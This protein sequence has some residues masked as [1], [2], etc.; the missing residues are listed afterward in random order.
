MLNPSEEPFDF[1]L[2]DSSALE[3]VRRRLRRV[4]QLARQN[5]YG[6][7]FGLQSR[8]TDG[9]IL[10]NLLGQFTRLVE[11]YLLDVEARLKLLQGRDV[12]LDGPV[13]ASCLGRFSILASSG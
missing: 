8:T 9:P 10:L 1:L 4:S 11:R 7:Y 3:N 2:R 13:C 6:R 12:V 5:E